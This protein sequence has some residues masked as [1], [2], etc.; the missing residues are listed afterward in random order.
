MSYLSILHCWAV[1]S[2]SMLREPAGAPDLLYYGTG[3]STHWAQQSNLNVFAAYAILGTDPSL[4]SGPEGAEWRRRAL[5]LLRYSLRTHASGDLPA[6]DG[7]KWGRHWISA[8]GP[9]RAQHGLAAIDPWLTPDDRARLRAFTISEADYLLKDYPVKASLYGSSGNCPESNIWNGN[10][11]IRAATSYPD[12]PNAAAWREKGIR[13][14]LNGLCVPADAKSDEPVAGRPL[15]E[16][17]VGANF[18]P[19]WALD[20]HG[21]F[22]VGY[23]HICL[24]N[25][26]MALYGYRLRGEEPPEFLLQHAADLWR[27]LRKFSF[28]DGR[29]IRIGGDS[30]W[31]YAYC[32]AFALASYRLAAHALGDDSAPALERGLADIFAAEQATNGD[33]FFYSKRLADLRQRS[34]YNYMRVESDPPLALSCLLAWARLMDAPAKADAP[35]AQP[36]ATMRFLEPYHGAVLLR[37]NGVVRSSV[38]TADNPV[39][40][41]DPW[42]PSD[43]CLPLGRSDLAEWNGSL[44]ALPGLVRGVSLGRRHSAALVQDGAGYV[45]SVSAVWKEIGQEGEGEKPNERL[46][47][48]SASAALPDERSIVVLERVSVLMD[49][50]LDFFLPIYLPVPNDLFNGLS[51]TYAGGSFRRVLPGGP[52][53]DELVDTGSS[54]LSIDGGLLNVSLAYGGDALQIRRFAERRGEY[55]HFRTRQ[56]SIALDAITAG[57]RGPCRVLRGEV[58]ADTGVVVTAGPCES[59]ASAER[60]PAP[61]GVRAVRATGC[62]GSRWI[63]A[64]NFGSVPAALPASDSGLNS[65]LQLPPGAARLLPLPTVQGQKE[66][67]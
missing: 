56:G 59:P 4:R 14:L 25:L 47:S 34:Y 53:A 61:D 29:L 35:Y 7:Q 42:G 26:A 31:R 38:T 28:P 9:E 49:T 51:R 19:S 67:Q 16:W 17:I 63:F 33:G 6:T 66:N 64:A 36:D 40:W 46:R 54:S 24:S 10:F 30:R 39:D 43:L 12:A 32:Q 44:H 3:E 23:S 15:R 5:A 11:L 48:D 58:I 45:T 1:A 52:S 55:R 60:I 18:F 50:S 22:N 57:A 20:H 41:V 37:T 13:F 8:L 21:Y 62:D 2:L 65:D 27:V